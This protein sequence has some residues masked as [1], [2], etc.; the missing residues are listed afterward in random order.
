MARARRRWRPNGRPPRASTSSSSAISPTAAP[1]RRRRAS[2][3]WHSRAKW[4]TRHRRWS[5]RR[6]RCA[7]SSSTGREVQTALDERRSEQGQ[8]DVAHSE[9]RLRAEHLAEA[10]REKYESDVATVEPGEAEGDADEERARVETLRQ[11]LQRLGEVNVTAIDEL[12]EF[13]ERGRFPAHPARRPRALARR[14]RA[15]HSEA[16]PGLA[17]ALRGDLCARQRDVPEGLPAPVPRR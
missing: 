12:R 4:P 1:A 2:G 7:P 8:A 13:E 16:Q 17:H 6:R 14:S 15:H 9:V 11:R 3:A 10:M 5:S